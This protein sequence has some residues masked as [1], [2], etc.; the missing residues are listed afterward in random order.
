VKQ[1]FRSTELFDI[2]KRGDRCASWFLNMMKVEKGERGKTNLLFILCVSS[3]RDL[4]YRYKAPLCNGAMAVD[5]ATAALKHD[6]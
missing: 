5:R 3:R 6:R 4:C 2:D 1:F